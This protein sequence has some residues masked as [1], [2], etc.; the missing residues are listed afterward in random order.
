[1]KSILFVT[2]L[3]R[4]IAEVKKL[5]YDPSKTPVRISGVA[6]IDGYTLDAKQASGARF[7]G[8]CGQSLVISS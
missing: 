6:T 1:M 2:D 3:E 5:G 4:A 7:V 8:E